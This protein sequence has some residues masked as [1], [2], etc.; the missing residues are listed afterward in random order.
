MTTF[1]PDSL[2][3]SSAKGGWVAFMK[4]APDIILGLCASIREN[5]K[6]TSLTPSKRRAVLEANQSMARGALRVLAVAYRPMPRLPETLDPDRVEQR[7]VFVGLL[8]MIDPPRP[9][10][11]SAIQLARQAGL[12]V[13]S[14]PQLVTLW[15]DHAHPD[16]PTLVKA[17]PAGGIRAAVGSPA[18]NSIVVSLVEGWR[19]EICHVAITDGQGR[20]ARYKVID[21]SFRNWSG[22]AMALR[23]GQ[24]SDFPLCNK[25]FNLSYCG[26]DL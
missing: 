7:M 9:E 12:T 15:A 23:D 3:L 5:G 20:F 14:S 4:G 1:H 16:Q 19:G 10:I 8:G 18:A 11:K 2:R 6:A 21:P 26:H 24:I 17:L 25:S 13:L 22:L